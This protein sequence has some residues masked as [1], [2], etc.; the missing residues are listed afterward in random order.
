MD[1]LK[2]TPMQDLDLQGK[3]VLLRLDINSPINAEKRIINENRIRKSLPTLQYLIDQNA[4]IAIIAHQGDTLDY[5]N[6]IP[7]AEHAEKL[8]ALLGRTVTYIDDVCGPAAQE[9]VKALNPG[10]LVLLGNVRYLCEEIST[11]E[12]AVK[13]TP[14]E[15]QSTYLV[16]SLAPLFDVYINDAFAAAHR[17]CP[18]MVAFQEC[19]PTAA[20][21]LMFREVSAL[22]NILSTPVKPLVFLLGGAKISD[23]FGMMNQVLANGTA[24]HILTTG[25]TGEIFLL[26]AGY[27]IGP[28]KMKFITDRSLDDFI[29]D[30]KKYLEAYPGKIEFPIDLAYAKDG[31]RCEISVAELPAD[32]MYM[33]IGTQTIEK[34]KAIL[35]EAKSIFVNGPSGVYENPTFEKGTK[36]LFEAMADATG[37][38]VIG[39]GDSVTAATKY[40]DLEKINYICTAGGAMVRFLSGKK[41]P[42]ISAMEKAWTKA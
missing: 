33:D 36:D 17:N 15:M 30:A 3:R 29:P 27:D 28:T 8:S 22:S 39:G 2:I 18:S 16:R 6:L 38:S 5:Q 12:N 19:L 21:E 41:L 1:Q 34:Y 42:L 24:D 26:A 35:A 9:A 20:G 32:E 31:Q 4:R 14:P 40:C 11:F 37:Y 25:V 13:L 10:E 23:A 7:M